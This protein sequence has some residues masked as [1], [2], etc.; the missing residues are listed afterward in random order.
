MV[1]YRKLLISALLLAAVLTAGLFLWHRARQAPEAV[2]LLPEGEMLIYADLTPIHLFS[3]TKTRPIQLEGDYRNFVEQT[4]IQFERDLEQVAMSR[5][6]APD[7]KDTES[8][9]IFVGKFDGPR[10]SAYLQKSAA[11]ADTYRNHLIFSIPHQGHLVR[12]CILDGRRVAVTNM[13]NPAPM[14]AMIDSSFHP[15]AGPSLLKDYYGG[16]PATS[17]A[18]LIARIPAKSQAAQFPDGW[19]FDFLENTVTVASL[20]YQGDVLFKAGV[21]APS[22]SD[23]KRITDAA[24][25][26]LLI[27]RSAAQALNPG[28]S[29]P[30]VKAA[31]DSVQVQQNKNVAV[32]TATLSQRVLKKLVTEAQPESTA[33]VP[34]P[35]PSAPKRRRRR[36]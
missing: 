4:G 18:W 20:R 16:I 30:D 27:S 32:I 31:F 8:S 7:G 10:L 9:E 14:R 2:R 11:H 17:L 3:T 12:V 33:P 1:S 5:R 13:E 25:G 22:E 26:F 23:A 28:G 34:S 35:S 15:P 29:D 21:I 19:S 6:D 24:T 36:R